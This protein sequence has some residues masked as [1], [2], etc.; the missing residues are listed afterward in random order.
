MEDVFMIVFP[1]SEVCWM[2]CRTGRYV[3]C[4]SEKNV[5]RPY[6]DVDGPI[7]PPIA[8]FRIGQQLRVQ[9]AGVIDQDLQYE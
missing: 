9:R 5:G 4:I 1:S 2:N 7:E 6:L 8:D 3:P